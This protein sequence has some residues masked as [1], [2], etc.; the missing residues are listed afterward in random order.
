MKCLVLGLVLL[1]ALAVSASAAPLWAVG[2]FHQ[3]NP[4]GNYGGDSIN[5]WVVWDGVNQTCTDANK[6]ATIT[7]GSVNFETTSI[8][9]EHLNGI[10]NTMD[11]F[12][13][14]DSQNNVICTFPDTVPLSTETWETLVCNGLS[15][16]GV[17]TLTIHPLAASPWDN[18]G[19]LDCA[20]YGQVAIREV[21]FFGNQV[22]EFG[23]IAA[24][25]AL[26]GAVTGF[27]VLKKK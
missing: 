13:V 15:L 2:G 27:F 10:A 19:G 25:V 7:V 11:G 1:A 20:T 18:G 16:N 21:E 9:I 14:V 22:P 8:E 24:M 12:D 26:A 23:T 4:S 6:D 3:C 5:C 17:Q